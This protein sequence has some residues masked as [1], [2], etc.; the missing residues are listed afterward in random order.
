VPLTNLANETGEVV[1]HLARFPMRANLLNMHPAPWEARRKI[2]VAKFTSL[3]SVCLLITR[4]P[5]TD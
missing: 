2:A 3:N 1:I 5:Q 4:P